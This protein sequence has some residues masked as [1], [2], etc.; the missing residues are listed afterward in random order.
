MH[1]ILFSSCLSSKLH[2]APDAPESSFLSFCGWWDTTLK[3]CHVT[4]KKKNSIKL[5]AGPHNLSQLSPLCKCM[6]T[7]AALQAG[8]DLEYQA[9]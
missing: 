7:H 5:R 8:N 6:T 9:V 2:S 4:S 3:E 1:L